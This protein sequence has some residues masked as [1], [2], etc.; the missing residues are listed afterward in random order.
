MVRTTNLLTACFATLCLSLTGQ[1]QPPTSSPKEVAPPD[2]AQRKF[3]E[4]WPAFLGPRGDS[5]S[6]ESG[7]LTDWSQP[8]RIFWHAQLGTSY[9]NCS[10][11][12]G[13][14]FVFDRVGGT[15]RL[16]CLHSE[17]GEPLWRYRYATDYEDM[18]GYNNGPRCSPIVDNDRVYIFGAEGRL[19]CLNAASGELVWDVDTAHEFGVVQNFFGVGSAPVVFEDLLLVVIGGS[20]IESQDVAPGRLEQ[21]AGNGSGVV[22]FDKFTGEV[23]YKLSDELASYATISVTRDNQQSK[24]FAFLRGGIVAFD[25]ATGRE[26]AFFRWRATN[27]ESVNAST[28][29][30]VNNEVFISETYGPGSCLLALTTDALKVVW[31]DDVRK[32][33]KA[34]QTHWNTAIHHKGFLYGCSGRH[35]QNAEL[36]CIEWKTGK[37]RWSQPGLTRTSLLFVDGH[38]VCL[39]EDGVLRLVVATPDGYDPVGETRL[40]PAG[41]NEPL[42]AYPAWSAPVLARGLMYVRGKDQLV[43]V[44][45]IHGP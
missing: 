22:A 45:L 5:K 24:A 42:L 15:S 19:V 14:C 12:R 6:N 35:T 26:D 43:C 23:R 27:P 29:V 32:R 9:G 11:S 34:M 1:A 8:P 13:R 2:L 21:V 44:E 40:V 17:T 10:I 39:G 20:P 7:I 37:V 28:P 31:Q 33:T 4:D 3:G 16:R 38:F 25:P 41:E 36:R 18:Y 30:I